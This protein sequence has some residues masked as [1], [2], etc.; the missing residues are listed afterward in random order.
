MVSSLKVH[1]LFKDSMLEA[2]R[3]KM[4]GGYLLNTLIF[5]RGGAY[6]LKKLVVTLSMYIVTD[7]T[8]GAKGQQFQI[9]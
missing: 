7:I 5:I 9:T 4:L 2:R 3:L 1:V 8:T 6:W